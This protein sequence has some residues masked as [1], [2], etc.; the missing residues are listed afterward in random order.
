MAA[1]IIKNMDY[2]LKNGC[3]EMRRDSLDI[4]S[5]GIASV[6]PFNATLNL[7]RIEEDEIVVGN[8]RF[9]A[10]KE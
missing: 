5:C 1:S 6:I 3:I 2:L 4:I 10:G 7:I 9:P 8:N